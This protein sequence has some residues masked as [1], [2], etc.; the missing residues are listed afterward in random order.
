MHVCVVCTRLSIHTSGTQKGLDTH[1]IYMEI[2]N[3][4]VR[5]HRVTIKSR[6]ELFLKKSG[7]IAGFVGIYH[8]EILLLRYVRS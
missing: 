3:E 7:D 1:I 2:I 4:I 5:F 6:V 8:T